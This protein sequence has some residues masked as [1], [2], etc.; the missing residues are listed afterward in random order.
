[1]KVTLLAS[2]VEYAMLMRVPLLTGLSLVALPFVSRF[3]SA[4][5]LLLGLFDVTPASTGAV[6]AAAATLAGV[7]ADNARI[8]LKHS[9]FRLGGIPELPDPATWLWFCMAAGLSLP[10]ILFTIWFSNQENPG[11]LGRRI[12]WAGGGWAVTVAL[13]WLAVR[14][15][16]Y[17]VVDGIEKRVSHWGIWDGY[18]PTTDHARA[19][20]GFGVAFSLYICF[21]IYGYKRLG[22]KNTV[23][24]LC[25]ALMVL[26]LVCSSL[27]AMSFFFDR[28]H[29]PL[30][31]L[32]LLL[33]LITAQFTASDHFYD[34]LPRR[35]DA[36][37][38]PSPIET[39]R[40]SRA[41]VRGRVVVAAANGGGIQAAAWTAQVLEGLCDVAPEQF[42]A[43]LR[44]ISSVSGGSLGSACYAYRQAQGE[45]ARAAA[46][47]AS[48]SSLDE[49]AWGVGWTDL[50]GS[51]FPWVSHG[52]PG[53]GRALEKAWV[54]NC[55]CDESAKSKLDEP[56]SNWNAAVRRGDL[57]ALVLNATLVESGERLLLGTTCFSA[58]ED[59]RARVDASTL[60]G[61][62]RDVSAVTAARL[63]ASFPYV[64][65]ASRSTL[66]GPQPH[67]V[68]GGY[69]DNY[70]MSTLVE[71]LD[72][73]LQADAK[74]PRI[75]RVVESV[76][77]IQ[78]HG[79]PVAG[80][81]KPAGR[82]TNRGWF[83]QIFAPLLTL[84]AVR[85]AGQVSHNDIELAQLQD[86]WFEHGVPIHSVTF[87]FPDDN[88]PLSWHLTKAQKEC[89]IDRWIRPSALDRH[90]EQVRAFLSGR[91]DLDCQC[92]TCNG[93]QG[94]APLA[95]VAVS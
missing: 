66:E 84:N 32:L 24:A 22:K 9:A 67:V 35:P 74:A 88:A 95:R 83:F 79:S 28:W 71:W 39:L 15:V 51:V 62:D 10:V 41:N 57:P 45:G 82:V 94:L 61:K 47:A 14:A 1:M 29:V 59:G 76:L 69:Y 17:V 27:S 64:T 87:E 37:A 72:E 91:D 34:L 7:I 50:V 49:V 33:G 85:G 40:A 26:V 54:M 4:R 77:V 52:W 36:E 86:K 68:D 93:K 56:L 75:E 12:Q 23:P 60:H 5:P 20:L 2:L 8:I 48:R 80:G 58:M 13:Q 81:L 63:S 90:R 3:T 6:A 21:G 42:A 55:S 92:P 19:A 44:L 70:G 53:R 11:D 31:L 38:A 30:L 65:P 89:V 25:S 43:S 16:K 73:S 78:I 46:D 18:F